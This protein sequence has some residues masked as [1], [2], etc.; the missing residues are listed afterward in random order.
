MSYEVGV[1]DLFES[2]HSL[3]GD[4]FGPAAQL[5]GHTYRVE[6]IAGGRRLSER[7]GTLCDIELI[8]GA[9]GRVAR[10]MLHYRVLDEVEGLKKV[11]NTTAEH[12]A[13]FIFSEVSRQLKKSVV[14]EAV[15][16]ASRIE[17]LKVT[18]WENQSSFASFRDRV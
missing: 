15:G 12:V 2:A 16:G 7:D 13:R 9:L 3:K 6:V 10:G 5:H 1:T 17:Y 4:N 18:V 11:N 14:D 8:R